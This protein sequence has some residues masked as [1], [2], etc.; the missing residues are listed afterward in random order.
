MRLVR[1]ARSRRAHVP[2][3]ALIAVAT[4][5]FVACGQAIDPGTD[6]PSQIAGEWPAY[7]HDAGGSGFSPL[8]Q[9]D[10]SNVAGLDV[11]WTY[12][13]GEAM[14]NTDVQG[15]ASGCRRCHESDLKFEVTPVMADGTLYLSTPTNRVIALDPAT[16]VERWTYDP[17]IDAT[18]DYSEGLVSRGVSFRRRPGPDDG[19]PCGTTVFLATLDA[20][21]MA[22]DGR[23][24]RPCAAFG[25]GGVVDLSEG[26]GPI[27]PGQYE[28]TSPPLVL[29]DR[30]I[31]GSAIGDNRRVDVEKGIVR[32]FDAETGQLHWSWDPIP[33]REGAPGYETWAPEAATRTGAANAWAPLAGDEERGLVFVPTG[34]AAPDHYGG[35]RPGDNLF[36]NSVVALRAATGEIAWHFQVVHHDLWDY[37]VPAQ[38]T[39]A[40]VRRGDADVPAVIVATKMGHLFVLDRETGTPLFDVEERPVP[41]S[42][43]PG[44]RASP[45]QPFPT[46]PPT[47]H[48]PAPT[49]DQA[50]GPTAEDV[51]FCREQLGRLRYEGPFTPPSL[52][53]TLVYPGLIGGMNWDGTAVHPE[54][55]VV[56]TTVKRFPFWVRL[57]PR[58]GF[59][60]A[61]RQGPEGV[62]FTSQSG[63]PYGM[64]R[65]PLLSASGVP[66]TPP[67]WGTLTAVDFS[68]GRILWEVP[69]GAVPRL[70]DVPEA[71][72]WGSVPFGGAI[73]TAGD[74]VFAGSSMDPMVRAFDIETGA[75]LWEHD[76]P[77]SGNATPM[78]YLDEATGKQ[79]VV[80]VAGGYSALGTT[81][82]DAVVAFALP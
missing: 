51:A 41:P 49:P 79:Y 1:S 48:P 9:I 30:V 70:H 15:E 65:A 38:P 14:H 39:L 50:W 7:A 36:A 59:D 81:V 61:R 73:V 27:D 69:L 58:D 42:T 80:I 2:T 12:R 76:L 23:T 64:S 43:V 32:A 3:L 18:A 28:M 77:A 40:V 54:R 66:C 16:G 10:R 8:S 63:T 53:G 13:T 55:Q 4:T 34:S 6:R 31:V 57:V 62:Q 35:E 75:V 11:A 24:G 47:L 21:L 82:A 56:V 71:K 29:G 25:T 26:V 52:E 68:G 22:L 37:D 60:A 78:T 19:S 17:A 33:R 72:E 5:G 45:T 67:P 20:R 74:L 46:H 44:E